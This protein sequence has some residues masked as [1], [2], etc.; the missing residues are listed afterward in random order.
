MSLFKEAHPIGDNASGLEGSN[1][2]L[3]GSNSGQERRY[4][5][6]EG[7]VWRKATVAW[8]EQQ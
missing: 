1:N 6:L 7:M 5:G 2:S 8:R 3:E 4:I